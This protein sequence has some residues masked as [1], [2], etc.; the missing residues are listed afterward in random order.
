MT[1]TF[2]NIKR[3][4]AFTRSI[5]EVSTILGLAITATRMGKLT[6]G[7]VLSIQSRAMVR[8]EQ[9]AKMAKGND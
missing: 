5:K 8:R 1:K 3:E 4:L 7:Q 9:I 2:E 6:K